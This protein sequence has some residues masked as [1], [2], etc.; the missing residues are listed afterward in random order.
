MRERVRPGQHFQIFERSEREI[1]RKG[2]RH[3]VAAAGRILRPR[4]H[5]AADGAL[6]ARDPEN[7][8]VARIQALDGGLL[9]AGSKRRDQ[10]PGQVDQTD[11]T[12]KRRPVLLV[13]PQNAIGRGQLAW[14]PGEVL[15]I[16]NAIVFVADFFADDVQVFGARHEHHV[17]G[18]VVQIAAVIHVGVIVAAVPP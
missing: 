17:F 16:K 1:H 4:V 10:M 5:V 14:R 12:V 11:M 3:F 15:P 18:R 2:A 13:E 6:L 8:G 9:V 7:I